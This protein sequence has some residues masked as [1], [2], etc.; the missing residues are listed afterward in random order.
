MFL[1]KTDTGYEFFV[2]DVISNPLIPLRG[3][4]QL[5]FLLE[6]KGQYLFIFRLKIIRVVS[7]WQREK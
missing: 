4:W 7:V 2:F 6:V 3:V 1:S 5:Q